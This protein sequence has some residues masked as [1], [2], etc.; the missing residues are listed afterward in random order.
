MSACQFGIVCGPIVVKVIA[1]S[2]PPTSRESFNLIASECSPDCSSQ[3]V[4][5]LLL[6]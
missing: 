2:L 6:L 5:F 4:A 3:I 1:V